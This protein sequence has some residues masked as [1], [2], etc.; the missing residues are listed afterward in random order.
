VLFPSREVYREA[1][2]RAQLSAVAELLR[3]CAAPAATGP[4]SGQAALAFGPAAGQEPPQELAPAA[5][6]QLV[7]P[8]LL[9]NALALA[10]RVA[11]RR[12]AQLAGVLAAQPR[13]LAGLARVTALV[14]DA[15]HILC[16]E[17][18]APP[19]RSPIHPAT[20][21]NPIPRCHVAARAQLTGP[22]AAPAQDSQRAVVE[23]VTLLHAHAA[24]LAP[25]GPLALPGPTGAERAGAADGP[26]GAAG[27]AAG[28]PLAEALEEVMGVLGSHHLALR[29]LAS[30]R[31]AALVAGD[32]GPPPAP[33]VTFDESASVT[34]AP[35]EPGSAAAGGGGVPAHNH[36]DRSRLGPLF[37]E[38]CL[39]RP[40]SPVRR[41]RPLQG[42]RGRQPPRP[43]L[44]PPVRLSPPRRRGG[45]GDRCPS[46]GWSATDPPRSC[47][48]A[49]AAANSP[50][51]G[52]AGTA[53][54]ARTLTS[55]TR[56]RPPSP[57]ASP[58]PCERT[59]RPCERT[60]HPHTLLVRVPPPA[61]RCQRAP[62]PR[63]PAGAI[64]RSATRRSP[65]RERS[66]ARTR[67]TR[68][69]TRRARTLRTKARS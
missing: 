48:A 51:S 64:A 34:G 22:R 39:V 5:V 2:D 30:H 10:A 62:P 4:A 41:T 61:Q 40:S 56:A 57:I 60:P 63:A 49:T 33:E 68:G 23:L 8:A 65:S 14:Y 25:G 20:N 50:S 13:L 69:S 29:Q 3:R 35:H 21:R 67:S 55:A 32:P 28:A 19:N 1:K 6:L 43:A 7:P 31:L 37:W 52:G 46:R 66:S 47:T 24:A 18:P 45:R 27:A 15:A 12:P 42:R 59:L 54:C 9:A 16:P 36:M 11:A 17:A 44:V 58:R 53:A 38:E 26:A